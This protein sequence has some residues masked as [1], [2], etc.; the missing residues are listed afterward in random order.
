MAKIDGGDLSV[1]KTIAISIC[2]AKRENNEGKKPKY[3]VLTVKNKK[4]ILSGSR[5]IPIFEED[6]PGAMD[7]LKAFA[8]STPNEHGEYLVNIQA[9][10]ADESAMAQWGDLL[11]FPGGMVVQY[12]LAKGLCYQNDI[13]GNPVLIKGTNQRVMKDT[14]SVFIQVDFAIETNNGLEYRYIDKF[15]PHTRGSRIEQKLYRVPVEGHDLQSGGSYMTTPP[16]QGQM[17]A[18]M[19][20]PQD[21][22]IF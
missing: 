4:S 7:C 15:D 20:G 19:Q 21:A 6:A 2:Q 8:S 10:K 1:Y 11:E 14:V 9:F 13:D 18:P 3:L 17:Q 12:P 5:R 22:P 16:T